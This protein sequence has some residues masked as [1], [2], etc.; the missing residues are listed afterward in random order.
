M[1]LRIDKTW[2]G[3]MLPEDE[4]VEI[5]VVLG[6]THLRLEVDAPFYGDAPPDVAP[7][8]CWALWE[9]E[10]V[11]LFLV[12]ENEAYTEIE[13]GPFGHY[14]L[15]RLEGVRN[16][17]ERELPMRLSSEIAGRRW[18]G[19]AEIE[20]TYLPRTIRTLNAYAIHGS[21]TE[22]SYSAW[23]PVPGDGPDFH[24]LAYFPDVVLGE[25]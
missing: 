7:G 10:V 17:V 11:E 24:R 5:S 19:V 23:E 25:P 16:I 6:T 12:G 13:V 8:S 3:H 22:R 1:K 21:K 15:L 14:L 2:D 20:R 18:R 9:H 4:V